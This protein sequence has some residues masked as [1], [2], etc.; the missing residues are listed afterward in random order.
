MNDFVDI[1]QIRYELNE[2]VIELLK[3]KRSDKGIS[4]YMLGKI[5][6]I[7]PGHVARIETG[8]KKHFTFGIL[9]KLFIALDVK[10]AEIDELIN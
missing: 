1:E 4:Q 6:G 2:K 5:A 3:Q 10:F 9:A 8:E 7:D